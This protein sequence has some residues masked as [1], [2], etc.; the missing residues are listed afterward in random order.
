[1]QREVKHIERHI[2]LPTHRNFRTLAA[3][4]VVKLVDFYLHLRRLARP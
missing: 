4:F 1:M 3:Y 2:D